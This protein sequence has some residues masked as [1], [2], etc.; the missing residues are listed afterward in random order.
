MEARLA[1]PG[2][3]AGL[4]ARDL[5]ESAPDLLR[6]KADGGELDV[7]PVVAGLGRQQAR[8]EVGELGIDAAE[9]IGQ[10]AEAL[11][12]PRF[13]QR[14]DEERIEP[15]RRLVGA[16]DAMQSARVAAGPLPREGD[17]APS[18]LAECGLEVRELLA[19]EARQRSLELAALRIAE[20][21]RHGGAGGLLLQVRMVEQHL[22]EVRERALGPV[23]VGGRSE[24]EHARESTARSNAVEGARRESEG[25]IGR[26]PVWGRIRAWT[27]ATS[28]AAA[29]A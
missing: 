12:A 3:H 28:D 17:P 8:I 19:C 29:C 9:S 26:E 16:Y 2:E 6:G 25:A 20:E 10:Q 15:A 11:A 18:E 1:E 23:G 22:V 21:E 24:P 4:V 27:I 5:L 13:D 7:L 14:G